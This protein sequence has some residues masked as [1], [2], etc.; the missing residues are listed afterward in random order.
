MEE[1]FL[2]AQGISKAYVGV[3][4]LKDVSLSI[5]TG[6]VHCLVGENG[7]GKSTLIKIVGGVVQPD[8]G[9]I[10]IQGRQ[11]QRLQAIDAIREGI[12]II[13]QDLSLY[14]N[15]T[16]AENIA[17]NQIIEKNSRLVNWKEISSI[18]RMAQE[19][20]GENIDPSELVEN[21]SMAKRQT[22]AICR[23]LTQN[24]RLIIMDEPTSAITREEVD[25]LFSVITKLKEDGI[26]TLFVSHKLGEVFEIAENVTVLRDG[27]KV[28]QF[29]A[30]ELDNDSLVFHMTGQ[31]ISYT[32]YI[33]RR[34]EGSRPPALEV[35]GLTKAGQFEDINFRLEA[36]EILGMTGLVGSG[37]TEL[38][39]S[40]FG[41]SRPD[42]G[43]ILVEGKTVR[44]NSP[45]DA[46]SRGISYLPEDRLT[47]G[48]FE[49]QSIGDNIIVTIIR[50]L[51]NKMGLINKNEQTDLIDRWISELK[52]KTP[53]AE[54]A[55]SG[56]SGGN[57]QR[58]VLAKWLATNPKIFI[59]DGPTIGIDIAS[60][61]NIHEIIRGLAEKGMAIIVIS[62]EIP[63]VLQSCN[64][65]LIMAAGRIVKEIAEVSTVSEDDLLAVINE[66]HLKEAT[67]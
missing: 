28:G 42:S 39:L 12:E 3:Q 23:A 10:I 36:G 54:V 1:F 34:S 14:P 51:L 9:E 33:Y 44:I 29:K 58:V 46:T 32:P 8:R 40:I 22:V 66:G 55:A 15:L 26:A 30:S 21:L 50:K 35:R 67:G 57:Q 56:L 45:G 60:K 49:A 5:K 63:E 18:A 48:L 17:F 62:D 37:R 6:E 47:Q 7:S 16:V 2:Q 53:S 19:R 59:L 65:V 24:S 43:E 41:L 64:R 52:I 31:K 25:H 61:S 38:A 4:A 13:Y 27:E 20:I 11:Y